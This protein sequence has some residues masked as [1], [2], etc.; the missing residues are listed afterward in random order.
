[1][2][3]ATDDR[4]RNT[5]TIAAGWLARIL[6]A[7]YRVNC[8]IEASPDGVRPVLEAATRPLGSFSRPA[9]QPLPARPMPTSRVVRPNA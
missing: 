4:L 5:R 9:R 3:P 2:V 8:H 7:P 1:M 6:L